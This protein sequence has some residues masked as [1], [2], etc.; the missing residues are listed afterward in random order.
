[1]IDKRKKELEWPEHISW[2]DRNQKKIMLTLIFI[3]VLLSITARLIMGIVLD[4][5]LLAVLWLVVFTIDVTLFF[6]LI[7]SPSD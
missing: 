3:F 7:S 1:M 4:Y 2:W 5:P 6:L